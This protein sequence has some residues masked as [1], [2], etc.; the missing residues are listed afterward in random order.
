MNIDD[1]IPAIQGRNWYAV[2]SIVIWAIVALVK[3]RAPE[4]YYRIPDG[5]RW[6]PPVLLAAATGFVDG[7]ASGLPWQQAAMRALFAVV[8]MG[9]GAMGV[10]GAL[11]ASPLKYGG[12][13]SAV[14]LAIGLSLAV[15]TG[16]ASSKPASSAV[17]EKT[18]VLAYTG[19]VVALEVLDAREAAYLDGISQPTI[20]QLDASKARI[21]RL[22]RARDSLSLVRDW[23]SGRSDKP[24]KAELGQAAEALRLVVEELRADGVRIPAAVLDGI[25]LAELFAGVAS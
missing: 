17:A 10:H 15:P 19:A 6:L 14:L 11:A 7:F 4:W 22:K 24:A 9:V 21:E 20:A 18:A 13:A 16:C 3:N 23:L 8:T 2:A 1:L 25:Q 5:W 12:G